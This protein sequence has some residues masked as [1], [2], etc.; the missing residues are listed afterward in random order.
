MVAE[1]ME[2]MSEIVDEA[3]ELPSRSVPA[4]AGSGLIYQAIPRVMSRVGAVGKDRKNPQQGYNFR[5]I[6]DVYNALNSALSAEGVFVVPQVVKKEREERELASRGGEKRSIIYTILTIRHT[7]YASDGSSVDAVTLGEAMDSGDKSCN[8]AMSAAMKYALIEVFCIPTVEPKDT[9]DETHEI[10]PRK[11]GKP[12]K[13]EIKNDPQPADPGAFG[14][15]CMDK[16]YTP[17]EM[18][19]LRA[20]LGVQQVWVERYQA[21]AE[22]AEK[23]AMAYVRE[24]KFDKLVNSWREKA[25]AKPAGLSPV[26]GME[27]IRSDGIMADEVAKGN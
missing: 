12:A 6:D 15:A 22:A 4:M 10:T 11:N 5:G 17:L 25:K 16:G 9:E 3:M 23:M 26:I 7:L 21:D 2:R 8:K 20:A 1:S 27:E 13:L 19:K 14:E 18:E 24:G